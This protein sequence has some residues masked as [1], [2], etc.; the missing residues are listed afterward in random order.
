MKIT[1]ILGFAV[2][3]VCALALSLRSLASGED[4][5]PR[6]PVAASPVAS[7][8]VENAD[9]TRRD[10]EPAPPEARRP[11]ASTTAP[12][13][14]VANDGAP[15]ELFAA[16]DVLVLD[17][18]EQPVPGIG[19][20]IELDAGGQRSGSTDGTGRVRFDR[21]QGAR[22]IATREPGWCTVLS[23]VPHLPL[24]L[25]STTE[26]VVVAAPAVEGVLTTVDGSGQ[27]VPNAEVAWRFDDGIRA[28]FDRSLETGSARWFEGRADGRGE[29]PL[30]LARGLVVE[31]RAEALGFAPLEDVIELAVEEDAS[32]MRIELVLRKAPDSALGLE[33]TVLD[34][35]GL[36]V[37]NACV[38]LGRMGTR[39][40]SE[41]AFHFDLSERDPFDWGSDRERLPVR[42]TAVAP[43]WLPVQLDADTDGAGRAV[44]PDPIEIH[45][46]H[47]PLSISGLV[48]DENGE[49]IEDAVVFCPELQLVGN[50]TTMEAE[51]RGQDE[52]GEFM[53]S[54]RTDSRGRFTFGGLLDRPYTVAAFL[55][56]SLSR[57]EFE[58]VVP[59]SGS[60]RIRIDRGAVW[61]VVRGVVRTAA[62]D[63]LAGVSVTPGM[64]TQRAQGPSGS[65]STALDGTPVL[66]DAEGRFELRRVPKRFQSVSL[67]HPLIH[68]VH[69]RSLPVEGARENSA[70]ELVDCDLVVE[71]RFRFQLRLRDPAEADEFRLL[72]PEGEAA[73]VQAQSGRRYH[74]SPEHFRLVEGRS[75]SLFTDSTARTLV[76]LRSGTEVRR[77]DLELGWPDPTI[78][79]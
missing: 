1:W 69:G 61:P 53:V 77:V 39:T 68:F 46:T 4:P 15:A 44:W 23:G 38:E 28:R 21:V 13:P 45:L 48:V 34:A 22:R 26:V 2:L 30:T 50:R 65:W 19:V 78:V 17:L 25:G 64:V 10:L 9:Q 24:P 12:T 76:L 6:A 74:S 29:V 70:G 59:G 16:L 20:E 8:P 54:E 35:F 56:D 52:D 47:E 42:L 63:P 49:P 18:D 41:G 62:G 72:T 36:P 5:T 60:V 75:R 66:S 67:E 40:N 73:P 7:A 71:P 37:E 14:E 55:E 58:G 51:L 43:G 27:P 3:C 32:P 33:G 79:E 57:G 31:V 11:A